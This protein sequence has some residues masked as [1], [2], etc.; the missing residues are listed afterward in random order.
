MA[1]S[2]ANRRRWEWSSNF[3]S[4]GRW[5]EGWDWMLYYRLIDGLPA[6]HS[7]GPCMAMSEFKP[8][9]KMVYS[10]C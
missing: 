8:I 1:R 3:G 5:A 10:Q 9:A 4:G 7:Q 2:S 6:T